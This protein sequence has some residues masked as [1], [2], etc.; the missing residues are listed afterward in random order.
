MALGS[1]AMAG[2]FLVYYFAA[3]FAAFV[4][5]E[6]IFAFGM[7]LTSGPDSAYLYDLLKEHGAEATYSAREGTASSFKHLGMTIAFALGGFIGQRQVALPYLFA[8][9]ACVVAAGAAS[10][11]DEPPASRRLR[12]QRFCGYVPHMSSAL[13]TALRGRRMRYAILY[14][15][16]IF[17]LLRITL[18]LY[19]P[20]LAEAGLDVAQ[21]GLVFAALCMVSAL[22]SHRV[23]AIRAR[24]PS[25]A[26]Y[27]VLPAVLGGSYLVLGRWAATWGILLLV[28]QKAVDGVYSPLTKE[29]LNREITDSGARATVLSVESMVR[30][31]VF[32]LF[33]PAI[34]LLFD[35]FGRAAAFYLCAVVGGLGACALV[36]RARAAAARDASERQSVAM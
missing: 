36:V 20:Y 3:S 6:G 27:W 17:I 12:E 32:S 18:W 16:L 35:H 19:Q 24:L 28:A 22:C 31:M 7:T 5:A 13:A 11:L 21:I 4:A 8:A 33:A 34:G 14:S 15:S 30:R 23:E 9:A 25:G 29:L 1:L 10:L 2:A 26:I